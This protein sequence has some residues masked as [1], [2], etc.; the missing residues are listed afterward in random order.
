M[1]FAASIVMDFIK[2]LLEHSLEHSL[3][4]SAVHCVL[5]LFRCFPHCMFCLSMVVYSRLFWTNP[6]ETIA[7]LDRDT[8]RDGKVGG[9]GQATSNPS[10]S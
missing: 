2:T 5:T 6:E 9:V 4:A 8:R 3:A 7:F 1:N 10:Q